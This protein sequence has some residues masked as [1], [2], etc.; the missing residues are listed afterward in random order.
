MLTF[1]N[2][3]LLRAAD[4]IEKQQHVTDIH[5]TEDGNFV[6]AYLLPE[7]FNMR[8]LFHECGTPSC[9]AGYMYTMAAAEN[10]TY[11][12]KS[13]NPNTMRA[14]DVYDR[15]VRWLFGVDMQ[16]RLKGDEIFEYND[17][18]YELRQIFEPT[19]YKDWETWQTIPPVA[20][21]K[22]IRRYAETRKVD[23]STIND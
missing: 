21:A 12:T 17:R 16:Y 20:V 4:L 7:G 6:R 14:L 13:S 19:N 11:K 9:A 18:M 1:D 2:G 8:T 22:M 23:W 10:G 15:I 3:K 5:D